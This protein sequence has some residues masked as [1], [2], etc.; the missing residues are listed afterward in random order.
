MTRESAEAYTAVKRVRREEVMASN[1]SASLFGLVAML[2][3]DQTA[4]LTM[5]FE[6]T[7]REGITGRDMIMLLA[8][9]DSMAE[10]L[11]NSSGARTFPSGC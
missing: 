9:T 11:Q 7:L 4:G 10:L 3:M 2:A 6:A 5:K 1:A 8:R